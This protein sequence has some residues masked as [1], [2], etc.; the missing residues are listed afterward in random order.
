MHT[1]RPSTTG[2]PVTTPST[3]DVFNTGFNTT[4]M[5][6][7]TP[8]VGCVL[9]ITNTTG[10]AFTGGSNLIPPQMMPDHLY[11]RRPVKYQAIQEFE[12]LL[13]KGM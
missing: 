1:P 12:K 4:I 13:K 9:L 5:N 3:N 7:V 11:Q 8:R 6:V 2:P 10:E